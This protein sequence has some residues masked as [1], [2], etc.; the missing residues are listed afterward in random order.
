MYWK[1][2]RTL[3]DQTSGK[4]PKFIKFITQHEILP[5]RWHGKQ[6]RKRIHNFQT[7]H[8]LSICCMWTA[9]S[10]SFIILILIIHSNYSFTARKFPEMMN[11]VNI[12]SMSYIEFLHVTSLSVEYVNCGFEQLR[13][14][15]SPSNFVHALFAF[16]EICPL[17]LVV[18][19]VKCKWIIHYRLHFPKQKTSSRSRRPLKLVELLF[20]GATIENF[21]WCPEKVASNPK[22][23]TQ[24]FFGNVNDDL[25]GV[26]NILGAAT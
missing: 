12:L 26:R 3:T 25:L 1:P 21:G 24:C 11:S 13:G 19:L 22:K 7:A 4:E 14:V 18:K 5:W 8:S 20:K 23:V 2:D 6:S 9:L 10:K 16:P 15:Y 17:T